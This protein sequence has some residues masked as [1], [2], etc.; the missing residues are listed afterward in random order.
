MV[1]CVATKQIMVVPMEHATA[2]AA[3]APSDQRWFHLVD[4]LHWRDKHRHPKT[5]GFLTLGGLAK[6]AKNQGTNDE[7][8]LVNP[9]INPPQLGFPRGKT[10]PHSFEGV[11]R[12]EGPN[13]GHP[14]L[15]FDRQDKSSA[16][17]C[18]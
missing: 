14:L 3:P 9:Q 7:V 12:P 1:N 2:P 11:V 5:L 10:S 4:H 15:S 16:R 13:E 17:L 8:Y 18:R 6:V